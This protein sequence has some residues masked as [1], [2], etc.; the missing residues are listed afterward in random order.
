ASCR[1]PSN[2]TRPPSG[3]PP[4]IPK[5][6]IASPKC[7]SARGGAMRRPPIL[8]PPCGSDPV[9]RRPENSWTCSE[10]PDLPIP[11]HPGSQVDP[12][13]PGAKG[14]IL[15]QFGKPEQPPAVARLAEGGGQVCPLGGEQ[16][17]GHQRRVCGHGATPMRPEQLAQGPG[18]Q[19]I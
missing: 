3:W 17:A 11:V 7:S 4:T 13:T 2:S 1:R 5:S 6:I 9:F 12:V 8:R 19:D 16:P 10:R 18:A 15:P 14:D